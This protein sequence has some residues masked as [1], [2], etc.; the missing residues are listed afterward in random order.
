MNDSAVGMEWNEIR[1][2]ILNDNRNFQPF[3]AIIRIILLE[4]SLYLI[5]Y[6]QNYFT[7]T[8]AVMSKTHLVVF[9]LLVIFVWLC[10]FFVV[11][12]SLCMGVLS[13]ADDGRKGWKFRLLL[14]INIWPHCTPFQLHL[15]FSFVNQVHVT[16]YTG[17]ILTIWRSTRASRVQLIQ[18]KDHTYD[19]KLKSLFLFFKEAAIPS[20]I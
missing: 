3:S 14:G 16:L 15:H 20:P 8:L 13:V 18:H 2:F 6:L 9:H 19:L 7:W 4:K 11:V 17:F 1:C 12:S 5:I 10:L